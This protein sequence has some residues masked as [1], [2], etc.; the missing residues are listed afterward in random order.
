MTNVLCLIDRDTR[1]LGVATPMLIGSVSRRIPGISTDYHQRKQPE[2]G[3][4]LIQETGIE[5]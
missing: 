4:K 5:V 2:Q 1:L 3:L